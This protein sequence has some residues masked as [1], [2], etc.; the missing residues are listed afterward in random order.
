MDGS[1]Y[2][3]EVE[4]YEVR[5]TAPKRRRRHT[6]LTRGARAALAHLRETI[7]EIPDREWEDRRERWQE[8]Q[9]VTRYR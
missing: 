7:S 1:M 3:F 8:I 5:K 4:E 6:T 9:A 2:L